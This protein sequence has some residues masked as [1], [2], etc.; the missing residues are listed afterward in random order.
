MEGKLDR[1][2]DRTDDGIKMRYLFEKVTNSCEI[3]KE[4][5]WTLESVLLIFLNN[6][7]KTKHLLF[8]STISF[9]QF[10]FDF[11]LLYRVPFILYASAPLV[12]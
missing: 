7:I 8:L 2:L 12:L 6:L 10:M 4:N 3:F 1:Q 11:L 5:H 9:I